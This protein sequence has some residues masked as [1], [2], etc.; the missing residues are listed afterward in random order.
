MRII[1]LAAAAALLAL[2]AAAQQALTDAELQ[3]TIVGRTATFPDGATATWHPNGAYV[4]A[5]SRGASTGRYAIAGGQV[6]VAFDNQGGQIN[7]NRCD[8]FVR[9]GQGLTLINGQG[10]SFPLRLN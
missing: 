8:R 4:Y 7:Q 2:P 9:S 1:Y 3:R 10:R 6:C 5:G